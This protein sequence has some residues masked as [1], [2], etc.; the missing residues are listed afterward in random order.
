MARGKKN[1]KQDELK[2]PS[3]N[4]CKA[5]ET[6]EKAMRAKSRTH[7]FAKPHSAR[8]LACPYFGTGSGRRDVA[9]NVD[10]GVD[11]PSTRPP[12]LACATR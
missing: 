8:F 6:L 2:V 1:E 10:L 9:R 3:T 5:G 4:V 7:L 11:Q 12:F